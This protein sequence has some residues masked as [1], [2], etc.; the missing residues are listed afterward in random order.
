M[1][2]VDASHKEVIQLIAQ[3]SQMGEVML[4]IR[5]KMPWPATA[6]LHV[7]EDSQ[8]DNPRPGPREVI[9]LRPNMQTS[10]GFVL[11]SNTLRTG[12]MICK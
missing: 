1:T 11:Q 7:Q 3:A 12:C 2:A 4:G 10:F 8:G 6:P 5:R 9:V